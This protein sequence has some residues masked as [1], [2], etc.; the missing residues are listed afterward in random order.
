MK[1]ETLFLLAGGAAA[2][3]WYMDS[4]QTAAPAAAAPAAQ[5][6][7]PIVSVPP[8][9]SPQ[10]AAPASPPVVAP[11]YV[12][13]VMQTTDPFL[14]GPRSRQIIPTTM[15]TQP[16]GIAQKTP[17]AATDTGALAGLAIYGGW[18]K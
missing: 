5:P 16:Q 2:L 6:A 7:A 10:P 18:G 11:V 4:Q 3:L 8:P 15:L 9:A 12:A 17:R 1:T 14:S 13:P